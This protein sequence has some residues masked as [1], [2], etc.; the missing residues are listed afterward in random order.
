MDDKKCPA[1][2]TPGDEISLILH[3]LREFYVAKN[4]GTREELM[5]EYNK[6]EK[7]YF[8]HALYFSDMLADVE[9]ELRE[10]KDDSVHESIGL[11]IQSIIVYA[12]LAHCV[13]AMRPGLTN[14]QR[15]GWVCWAHNYLGRLRGSVSGEVAGALTS[16][17]GRAK[18]GAAAR[19]KENREMKLEV[20]EW[21]TQ[22]IDRFN[23]LDGA[24][25]AIA[26]DVVPIK[27]RT[28]RGWVGQ[29]KKLS[30]EK[31]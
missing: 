14:D 18:N 16:I 21:L 7:S 4:L 9:R 24:A 22:N 17:K 13:E 30:S 29:W 3:L 1:N 28:A 2:P 20:F 11:E 15:W 23:S 12:S 6:I 10:G 5:T 27:F 26:G 25:E 19:H 31:K 8:N